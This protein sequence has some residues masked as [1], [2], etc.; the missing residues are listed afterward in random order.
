MRPEDK[1]SADIVNAVSFVAFE[2]TCTR[3]ER[4]NR[5]LFVLCVI[6]ISALILSNAA[7]A[8][9]EAQYQTVETTQEVTQEAES[10]NN[11]FV[12]GDIYGE[13][14]ADNQNDG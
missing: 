13:G 5:R 4:S 11:T 1:S 3:L 6:L 10:G 8:S 12:G 9:Y 2:S 14:Q 7:W